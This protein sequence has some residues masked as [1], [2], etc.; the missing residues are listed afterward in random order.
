MA[1]RFCIGRFEIRPD[2]RRVLDQG[3]PVALGAR[4]FDLLLALHERRDRVASKCELLDQVWRGRPVE[5]GNLTVQVSA[6]RKVFGPQVVATVA[7]HGYRLALPAGDADAAPDGPP[8]EPAL[9]PRPSLAVLPFTAPGGS[10][11]DAWFVDGLV[12]DLITE[13]SRFKQI[14]VIARNS[15]FSYRGRQ[16]EARVI[17]RELGVRYLLEGSVQRIDGRLRVHAA[18]VDAASG[19]QVWAERYERSLGCVFE[20]QEELTHAIVTALWPQLEDSELGRAR[21]TG[22][23]SLDAY[24]LAL[25]AR[26]LMRQAFLDSGRAALIAQARVLLAQAEAIDADSGEVLR[27]RGYLCWLTLWSGHATA[28]AETLREGLAATRRALERD[29]GD[30][31]AFHRRALLKSLAGEPDNGLQDIRRAHALNPNDSGTLSMLATYEA[32]HGDVE[33]GRRLAADTLRMSPR[34]PLRLHFFNMR[35]IIEHYAG[36]P[37]QSL[38][39][40]DRGLAE[41]PAHAPSRYFRMVCLA[42][43]GRDAEARREAEALQAHAPAFAG[44]RL[45]GEGPRYCSAPAFARERALVARAVGAGPRAVEAGRHA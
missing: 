14:F 8:P 45:R 30:Y 19:A 26:G 5:E 36:E 41:A 42:A 13:C 21:L 9:P 7:G 1:R 25:R 37:A 12:E 34:D 16:V 43:L 17:G 40:C 29:P 22:A 24:L 35:Q 15:S 10:E 44:F 39:W 11:Q 4:A 3:Q 28:R 27:A 32:G 6:L 18:L 31:L 20:V 33:A 2:E 23:A 38:A